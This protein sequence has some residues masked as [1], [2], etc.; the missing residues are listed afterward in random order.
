MNRIKLKNISTLIAS[1]IT[2]S[3]SSTEFWKDGTIYWLKTDQL[4]ERY[5]EA[6]DEKITQKALEATSIKIFP[7][8][9]LSI[10]MYGE[11]RTRGNVSIIKSP[12]TTN[13]ACCNIVI[14]DSKADYKYVYYFLK[15]QYLELR[16]LSSGIRKNL[17]SNDIKEFEIN[18]PKSISEQRRIASV[19]SA[20]DDK[21]ELNN[22]INKELEAMAKTLYDYWFVQFDFPDANGKPYKASGGKMV[23]NAELK[24]EIPKGRE[25][26]SLGKTCKTYL[27]GTP[28][29]KIRE[30]W[31]GNI[32]WLN[33]G[34][35]EFPIISTEQK[36]TEEAIANSATKLLPKGT[37]LISI[38]RHLRSNILGIDACVNQS[39]VGITETGNLRTP[40]LYLFITREIPRLMTLRTGAQQPHINKETV[41]DSL[42]VVPTEDILSQF[43][44]FSQPVF[45]KLILNA[46]QSQE[47]V[48]L[49]DWLLPMLMNGQVTVKKAYEM[50]AEKLSMVAEP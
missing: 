31:R 22:K 4:G 15:T 24:R 7:I 14:D 49:R 46:K 50:A 37:V 44:S 47:L 48:S 17:N 28:S 18:I 2:P 16:R 10:A 20:L 30:Y 13:Q 45:E 6:T 19:L 39:V 1:G 9:S 26:K 34:E 27:G 40:Y 29:T 25:V 23:Y 43:Y 35:A 3:R 8:N 41:D 33:S 42:I 32:A 21:I 38:T 36:I 5:I 12:M 11:G